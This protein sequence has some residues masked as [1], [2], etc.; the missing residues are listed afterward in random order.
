MIANGATNQGIARNARLDSSAYRTGGNGPGAF[1]NA[2]LSMQQV[3]RQNNDDV[4]AINLSWG[5]VPRQ[6]ERIDG[7]SLL[8]RGTDYFARQH[9]ALFVVGPSNRAGGR[10]QLPADAYN[11]LVVTAASQVGGVFRRVVTPAVVDDN[12]RRLTDLIAPGDA[13]SVPEPTANGMGT[14]NARG[15]T[16]YAA[17]HAT[18]TVALL[19]EDA[20]ANGLGADAQ[21]HEVMKDVLL[22]SADLVAGRLG[23]TRTVLKR[24]GTSTWDNSDARDDPARPDGPADPLDDEMGGRVPRR[25]PRRHPARRGRVRPG[26]ERRRPDRLG[27]PGQ[28]RPGQFQPLPAPALA[29]RQLDLDYADLGPPGRYHE[30]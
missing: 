19:Q 30:S 13:I 15:G 24:D 18:G 11:D 29:G 17:P 5:K 22:N 28:Q 23:M 7:D 9:D 4:P 14:Y 3:A 8:S 25:P 2:L 1:E 26:G 21:R 12:G 16:S 10:D 20:R 6:G 27:L